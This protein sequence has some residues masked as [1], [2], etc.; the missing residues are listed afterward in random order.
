M[1]FS[2]NTTTTETH[3]KQ[4]M[5]TGRPTAGN[6]V[7]NENEPIPLDSDTPDVNLHVH[8]PWSAEDLQTLYS[9]LEYV[10]ELKTFVS[11]AISDGPNLNMIMPKAP[12]PTL[13]SVFVEP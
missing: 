2:A 12:K 8:Y 13:K 5:T 10:H 11:L 7:N 4:K 6:E 9:H 3:L 1:N